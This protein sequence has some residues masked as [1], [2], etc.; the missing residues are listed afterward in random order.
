MT[1]LLSDIFSI[2]TLA[3]FERCCLS[4][5]RFQA[6]NCKVYREYI[7][8]LQVQP[9]QVQSVEQIPFLPISF[10]KTHEIISGDK[11]FQK[12]FT[13]SGT[14]GTEPSRHFVND[15]KVYEKSLFDG[16]NLFYESPDNYTFLALLPSYLE[17]E[18]SSLVYMVEKLIEQ[19]G[20]SDNGFY[21]HDFSTLYD[22]LKRL[23]DNGNKVLLIGVTYALLDFVEKY[24]LQFPEL[25]VMETGGMKGR[26]EELQRNEM[27][28]ILQKGFGV[29]QIHSEYGMTE[30]L[31]Q[32]YSKGNEIF[33][34]PPWMK[35]CIRNQYDPFSFLPDG[36]VGGVNVIDLANIYSCAFIET[37]DLGRRNENGGFE[38][39]GRFAQSDI[40]G[41]NL[42]Y[43]N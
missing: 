33:F 20:N 37:Q 38:I 34:S 30:L 41:C 35:I 2:K 43:E 25:I 11:Q 4:V 17:R 9:E 40:R 16:F 12:I 21:L 7:N 14:T 23:Q 27:H 28:E 10:F 5:F 39:L 1:N 24:S 15:L 13:S 29:K 26:R 19:S 42:M 8:L 18:G 6:V 3:D 22:C 31:S 36:T 32:A